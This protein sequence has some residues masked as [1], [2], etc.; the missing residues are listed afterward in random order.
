MDRP[1]RASARL[2]GLVLTGL[3]IGLVVGALAGSPALPARSATASAPTPV[4]SGNT[5]IDSRTGSRWIA[6]GVNWPS[7]E[8]ACQQGWAESADGATPAAAAAMASWG[9]TMVRIPLNQ[10]CW[11][12]V[13]DSPAYGTP[14]S[15][16]TAI[17]A[18]VST[19]N[20]AGLVAI[21]DLHWT[22]PTGSTA[23]GQRAMPDA[24]SA[25]FW[26]Q[27]AALFKNSPSVLF[28]TFNEPY[29]RG[30]YS[31]SWNCWKSG[32]C[33][34][35]SSNDQSPLGT[36]TY[37]AVG[38]TQIVNAIRASGATQPILLD[39]LNYANDL[40]GW[41]AN[42][43]SDSQ[44]VASWH[45]YPG[46]G[47]DTVTCWNSQI[48][49]VARTVPV[50]A[51]EF[52]EADGQST[53]MTQFMN[54]ADAAAIGYAP[55]AWWVTDSSDSADANLYA[56]IAN[57]TDFTPRAPSGTAYHDHLAS[58]QPSH[59]SAA[60]SFV[61]AAYTDVLGRTPAISDPG[62]QYWT[63]QIAAGAS[64][65]AI[66]RGFN[67]SDEYRTM[68]ITAAY[69]DVL[70]RAP[71]A[72][73]ANYWLR[74]MQQGTIQPDDVHR[75]F[76]GSDE[77]YARQGGG[78]DVG[79]VTALYHDVVGR[80][81][82][83]D[84]LNYWVGVL[85]SQGRTVV[86]DGLWFAEETFRTQVSLAYQQLLGRAAAPSEQSYW[87]GVARQVGVTGMRTLVMSSDEYWNRAATRFP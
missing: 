26:S 50:I 57:L 20:S 39:G 63:T 42:K 14:S 29:S 43:P 37:T 13:D 61:L 3:A 36:S 8:Y 71:D 80:V 65:G 11:L 83:T 70:Q 67:N 45:N 81:P 40:T 69:Q 2:R 52:G 54:W 41:L 12:G 46:Q 78:T 79:Y 4:V 24:Q 10:D 16:K 58:L 1:E 5:L 82:D 15:Y 19:L 64:R 17:A 25:T 22:A 68:K 77:F 87:S 21:L 76:I 86:V 30:P 34:V 51:T 74:L 28:E 55:W 47:C 27:V 60:M 59:N 49:P 23:D 75:T 44:L 18:W 31:V 62:V 56:L 72:G 32:G 35:P 9:I 48:L 66:A 6:H 73:G 53:F 33:R 85:R 7:F 84:G 38:Q